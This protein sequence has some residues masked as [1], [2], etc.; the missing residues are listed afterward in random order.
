MKALRV[1]KNNNST[2]KNNGTVPL[3]A[4]SGAPV[5]GFGSIPNIVVSAVRPA[6]DD[7]IGAGRCARMAQGAKK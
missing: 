1:A 6:G 2:A 7:A 3:S 4:L 5:V